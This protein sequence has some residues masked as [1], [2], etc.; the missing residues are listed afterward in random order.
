M[1]G[2]NETNFLDLIDN[3]QKAL[4]QI[5]N[6]CVSG[7]ISKILGGV[8]TPIFFNHFF[9]EK[10]IILCILKGMLPFKMHKIIYFPE[11]L[12]KNLGFTSKVR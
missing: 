10:N 12:L 3:N 5:K 4:G 6:M 8:G 9:L 2:G 7:N 1:I 11:N